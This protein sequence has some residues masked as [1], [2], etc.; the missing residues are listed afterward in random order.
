MYALLCV[1]NNDS[2]TE[3]DE[4]IVTD[5]DDDNNCKSRTDV[6]TALL[7]QSLKKEV[8]WE[9]LSVTVLKST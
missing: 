3:N 5:S 9:F 7:V 8:N 2:D 4:W 1:D 6:K